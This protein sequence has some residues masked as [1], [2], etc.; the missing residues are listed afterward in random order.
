MLPLIVMYACLLPATANAVSKQEILDRCFEVI[1][2]ANMDEFEE[3][4]NEIKNW[5]WIFNDELRNSGAECLSSGYEETWEY[6]ITSG[7][8]I[9]PNEISEQ[10]AALEASIALNNQRNKIEAERLCLIA[11]R[12]S[13]SQM[14]ERMNRQETASQSFEVEQAINEACRRLYYDEPN[15]ALTNNVCVEVYRRSGL[16][17]SNSSSFNQNSAQKRQ[18]LDVYMRIE[19]QL[20]SLESEPVSINTNDHEFFDDNWMDDPTFQCRE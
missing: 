2:A 12:N 16:P 6:S 19:S 3:I 18:L 1:N 20:K 7:R 9:D 8:F 11:R 4:A 13:I 5:Q 15:N 14:I 17:D 10:N